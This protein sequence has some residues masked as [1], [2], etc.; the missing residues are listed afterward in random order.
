MSYAIFFFFKLRHDDVIYDTL[1]LY[2]TAGGLLG[3]GN[4]LLQGCTIVM[5]K[6]FSASRFWEDCI[7]YRC[8]VC[9]MLFLLAKIVISILST[10]VV[11]SF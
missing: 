8:T 9:K 11:Y 6:K 10:D 1:P 7:Q 3:I 5:R 4:C 2:H